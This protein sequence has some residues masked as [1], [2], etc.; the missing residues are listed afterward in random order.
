[1]NIIKPPAGEVPTFESLDE[2]QSW[3]L[4]SLL[5]RGNAVTSRGMPTLELFPG[6]FALAHP[7]RR[8]ITNPER[9]WN[10]PLAI[11]ESCWHAMGSN[12][13]R[14]IEYYAPRWK[15]FTDGIEIIVVATAITS[16]AEEKENP[17]N[18]IVSFS[19][20]ERSVTLVAQFCNY[21]NQRLASMPILR[22]H[23]V[24]AASNF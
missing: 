2:V 9:R 12:D 14:F 18:G 6:S 13:L 16:S 15:E 4:S 17:A 24:L 3:V 23:R 10:L 7:R 20:C 19:C 22:T 8:C 11:G 21:S 5:A 1:M